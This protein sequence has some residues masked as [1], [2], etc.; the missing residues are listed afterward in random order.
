MSTL[1]ATNGNITNVNTGTIK[2]ATGNTTAMTID[3]TGRVLTPARPAFGVRRDSSDQ[4]ITGSTYTV[5]EF[6]TEEFDIGGNFDMSTHRFTAPI[7]GIYHFSANVRFKATNA[8]MD[9]VSLHLFKNGTIFKDLVQMN[10]GTNN[11]DNSHLGGSATVQLAASDYIELKGRISGGSP[12]FGYNSGGH[13]S[14]FN[15]F[16]VG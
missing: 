13:M 5:V 6:E 9:Y 1:I 15:G 12:A 3:S 2:D 10:S 8:T 14:N 4:S 7:A 16:F 11:M